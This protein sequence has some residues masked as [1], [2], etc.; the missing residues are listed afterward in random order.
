AAAPQQPPT[1][2][3]L[4][5][6]VELAQALIQR[7]LRDHARAAIEER[8]KLQEIEAAALATLPRYDLT[9][10]LQAALDVDLQTPWREIVKRTAAERLRID[11]SLPGAI[12]QAIEEAIRNTL[13][14]F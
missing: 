8:I 1:R 9:D 2:P 13:R 12:E 6:M 14:S 5:E 4:G 7:S 11:E 3:P 10:D